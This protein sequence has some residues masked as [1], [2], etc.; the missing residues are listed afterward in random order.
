MYG[1]TPRKKALTIVGRYRSDLNTHL[2]ADHEGAMRSYRR[3]LFVARSLILAG[4]I[5]GVVVPMPTSG[6]NALGHRHGYA[7]SQTVCFNHVSLTSYMHDASVWTETYRLNPTDVNT[8]HYDNSQTSGN[9]NVYDANYGDTT[10]AGRWYCTTYYA[11]MC[12]TS[13]IQYNLYHIT[14]PSEYLYHRNM[15]CHESGHAVGLAHT[16]D[17]SSCMKSPP[18]TRYYTDHDKAIINSKY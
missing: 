13:T 2:R 16:T 14:D 11:Y 15:T 7:P 1:G 18:S 5:A 6:S 8:C 10:W 4:A 3:L 17:A 12:L 9:V